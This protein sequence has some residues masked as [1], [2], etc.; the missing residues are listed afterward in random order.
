MEPLV[1][2]EFIKKVID[3][4]IKNLHPDLENKIIEEV[5]LN[6][7]NKE[8]KI[9]YFIRERLKLPKVGSDKRTYWEKRG[10]SKEE[11]EEKRIVNKMPSSP[12][13]INNWL[14]KVNEKTGKLYTKEEANYKI[15]SF[16]KLNKEF[17]IE[18]GYSEEDAMNKVKEYQKENSNKFIKK[19]LENPENYTDRTE[20]QINYW[21]KKGYNIEDANKKLKERQD[22]TSLEFHNNRYGEEDGLI[23]YNKRISNIAYN[24]SHK[25]YV[26]KYG[27]LEGNKLY[28]IRLKSRIVPIS[29][30]SKESFYFLKDIYKYLRKNGI[31]K[32]DI[33]WGVGHS[34]EWFINTGSNLFFYDF[35][36]PKLNIIIE[37]HGKM[38][39]PNPE[40]ILDKDNWKCLYSG[41]S[42]DIVLKSDMIK[43]QIAIDKGYEYIKVY[44]D[45][46]LH[47]KI[48]EIIKKIDTKINE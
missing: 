32:S 44:S 39:Q 42:Y 18:K 1:V 33:Y 40:K 3:D 14:N 19:I 6:G 36:I 11:I 21:I 9:K 17:W 30:A 4:K 10:W 23:R 41:L 26:D 15:K 25:Y 43:E 16:R 37:Y 5:L 48:N 46:N 8:Y 27:I 12:M 2:R 35:T 45:D 20:T 29:K 24:S 28:D 31:D 7:L 34:N 47:H 22:T 13:K 38:F